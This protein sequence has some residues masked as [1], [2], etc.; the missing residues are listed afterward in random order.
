MTRSSIRKPEVLDAD[1][2]NLIYGFLNLINLYERLPA[3]LYDFVSSGCDDESTGVALASFV[4]SS[5]GFPLSLEDIVEIQQVDILVTQQ[6]LQGMMWKLGLS[7]LSHKFLE[8][9]GS[10]PWDAPLSA[11]YS[12]LEIL[13]SVS[14]S[15]IDA[16]GI[17]M[18]WHDFFP[19][20]FI[21][22]VNDVL[23]RNKSYSTSEH[24][25]RTWHDGPAP[26]ALHSPTFGSSTPMTCFGES[27]VLCP[28]FRDLNR[29]YSRSSWKFLGISWV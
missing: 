14:Q 24:K 16:H 13:S 3:E 27:S 21:S 10:I 8:N 23:Y 6:W 19:L 20:L 29:I 22:E 9:P 25:W 2:P 7:S 4:H 12:I 28:T 11:A 26:L 1:D 17:S 18:V 15:S 5:L